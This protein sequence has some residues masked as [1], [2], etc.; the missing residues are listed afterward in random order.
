V[1]R[2]NIRAGVEAGKSVKG[3]LKGISCSGE[4]G[5]DGLW[6]KLRNGITRVALML[7][8][9][10]SG[11]VFPPVV[12]EGE[13]SAVYW[14]QVFDRAEEAGLDPVTL[15]GITSDG[16]NGLLSFLRESLP[17]VHQ[18]RCIWH[19]WRNASRIARRQIALVVKGMPQEK[20]RKMR[21]QL[22]R[23]LNRS[24]H[25]FF[26]AASYEDAEKALATL[27]MHVC[28]KA[29]R[30][31]LRPLQDAAL[32]HLM[33]CHQGLNRV[34][35]EWYWRDFRQRISHGRNHGS[36]QR[37]EQ[38]LLVWAIYRNFTPAQ[39]RSERKRAYRHPGRSPLEVAGAPPGH[40]SYLDALRV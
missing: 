27:A 5:T 38:A 28:G 4:M 21:R 25:H 10:S 3:H 35:P 40:L 15:N 11:L 22:S 8:D 34:S 30:E 16:S 24:L 32:M 6:A 37:L 2:W 9:Y 33:P 13:E 7:V 23:E 20:A 12:V 19:L 36:E 39:R 31:W 18:Q 17:A 1:H 14:E 26:D 29:L